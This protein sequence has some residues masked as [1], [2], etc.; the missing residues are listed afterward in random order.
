MP[1]QGQI[2]IKLNENEKDLKIQSG[3]N[4]NIPKYHTNI[5]ME[6]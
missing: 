1:K 4:K 6:S 3:E 5:N 2:N